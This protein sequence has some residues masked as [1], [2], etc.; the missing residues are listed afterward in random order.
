MTTYVSSG[1]IYSLQEVRRALDVLSGGLL[2]SSMVSSGGRV[3][4]ESGGVA[5]H[6]TVNSLGCLGVSSGGTV[7]GATIRRDGYLGVCGA[8]V[9]V[10]L[11][12]GSLHVSSGGSVSRTTIR[13]GQAIVSSGGTI[14]DTTL[15]GG[16]LCVSSGGTAIGTTVSSGGH[17]YVSSEG[18]ATAT[19]VTSGGRLS[20]LS[21]GTA[22]G[23]IVSSGG[24][25]DLSSPLKGTVNA[26]V[27]GFSVGGVSFQ[28]GAHFGLAVGKGGVFTGTLTRDD[29]LK[30]FSGGTARNLT[31]R[32]GGT[33]TVESG[34]VVSSTTLVGRGSIGGGGTFAGV[35]L[36]GG[37]LAVSADLS[38]KG[39]LTLA[40]SGNTLTLGFGADL[41]AVTISAFSGGDTIT[42]SGRTITSATLNRSN[43]LTVT[44][45]G[46]VVT[47]LKLGGDATGR[48]YRTSG[49]SLFAVI[50]N[51]IGTDYN[52][53]LSYQNR[54]PINGGDG[55][56][57]LLISG[58]ASRVI[59]EA[60]DQRFSNIEILDGSSASGALTLT[61]R[62]TLTTTLI[63]GA[64]HDLLIGRTAD[65]CLIGH[66]GNDTLNGGTGADT[67]LGGAGN[68][69]YIVDSASE[70][71]Y[72]TTKINGGID[73]GGT[74][75]V[76][77]NLSWELGRYFENLTLIGSSAINGTGNALAN[78]L[79]GNNEANALSGGG[80][81]DTLDGGGGRDT[82]TGGTDADI[83]RYTT[84][85]EGRDVITDFLSGTDKL[86]FVS[87]N[88]GS[89]TTAKLTQAH[90]FVS[91]TTGAA[92][93]TGAQF[94][95][96]TQ[97]RTLT[98]DSN[99]T[100]AGGST[101]LATL[102][103]RT[104]SASDFL[105]VVS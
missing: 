24:F 15:N 94:I 3:F 85:S 72:E 29:S 49:S 7:S 86:Q 57:T 70:H 42:L 88:F 80:G 74:D 96:N 4:V 62:R 41:S 87:R 81:A 34:S 55:I 52:D 2:V 5:S 30:V 33:V 59:S 82:L 90:R 71:I 65:D 95:F 60:S 35:V 28:S 39:A 63:G 12:G 10:T 9:G 17:V 84:P 97:A 16:S 40:G 18:T 67:L 103:S 21:G 14:S 66:G 56:D 53:Y 54:I 31:I 76:Q 32:S 83:F 64:G 20:I 99:G 69:T 37:S 27:T 43:L 91:N 38:L 105:M 100:K 36:S 23:T 68:D 101:T 89:L 98:Y 92:S 50:D 46:A 73:A 58:A 1:A 47:R 77:S 25:G 79:T 104:L 102:N 61:G 11:A 93:G 45:G 26:M 78:V 22:R 8:A 75:S 51:G 48:S 6:I 13:D 19:S 44:S